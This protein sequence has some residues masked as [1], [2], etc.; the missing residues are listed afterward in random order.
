M[1]MGAASV[2]VAVMFPYAAVRRGSPFPKFPDNRGLWGY[3]KIFSMGLGEFVR[4]GHRSH[5]LF[6]P[7]TS[8]E[9]IDDCSHVSKT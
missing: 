5:L 3:P 9:L 4:L 8:V 6:D 2:A 1:A 7:A